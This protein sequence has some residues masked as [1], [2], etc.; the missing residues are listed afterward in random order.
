MDQRAGRIYLES[1]V[2]DPFERR[3]RR[4]PGGLGS[5]LP[6]LALE[7]RR[8]HLLGA[9]HVVGSRDSP[10][11]R[12]QGLQFPG[13][14]LR[15]LA[16]GQDFRLG[17]D[18]TILCVRLGLRRTPGN[19]AGLLEPAEARRRRAGLDRLPGLLEVLPEPAVR[20]HR[21]ARLARGVLGGPGPDAPTILARSL[22]PDCIGSRD[23]DGSRDPAAY[24]AFPPRPGLSDRRGWAGFRD[25]SIGKSMDR[26]RVGRLGRRFL[27]G[28]IRSGDASRDHRQLDSWVARGRLRWA[29]QPGYAGRR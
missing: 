12:H 29:L 22:V 2:I 23:R 28:G 19:R 16:A 24:R 9:R 15:L 25:E 26:H 5:P 20:D 21:R 7:P 27:V 18:P 8:G 11:P 3:V 13:R 1:R 6:D 4:L 10:I 17:S 14:D